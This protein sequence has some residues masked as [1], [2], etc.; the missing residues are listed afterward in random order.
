[1]ASRLSQSE[2]Q[3]VGPPRHLLG[4]L[5]IGL[6]TRPAVAI[7]IGQF[8]RGQR[9]TGIGRQLGVLDGSPKLRV[10]GGAR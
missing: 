2:S 9:M 1:M 6:Q 5:G 10:V 4:G 3:A 8:T 7:E